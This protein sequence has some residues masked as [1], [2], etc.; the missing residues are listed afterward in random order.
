MAMVTWILGWFGSILF[1]MRRNQRQVV[2]GLFM[3]KAFALL[4][5]VFAS[6]FFWLIFGASGW[7]YILFKAQ[8]SVYFMMPEESFWNF[9]LLLVLCF[10]TK[11]IHL[12][13]LLHTQ[14]QHDIF[15]IDWE[16]PREGA[17]K[18][19]RGAGSDE[20]DSGSSMVPVSAWRSVFVANEWVKLQGQRSVSV[21]LTLLLLLYILRGLDWERCS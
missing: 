9:K 2:D 15:F 4:C 7:M 21:E 6:V 8:E 12:V 10:I 1:V 14:T 16:Q 3:L 18:S 5:S 19:S 11:T 17:P 13:D 20:E